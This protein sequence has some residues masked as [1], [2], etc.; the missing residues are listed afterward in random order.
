MHA[1]RSEA[2]GHGE[3]RRRACCVRCALRVDRSASSVSLRPP[4]LPPPFEVPEVPH[5]TKMHPRHAAS[6]GPAPHSPAPRPS[7][8]PHPDS[9]PARPRPAHLPRLQCERRRGGPNTQQ[10][11]QQQAPGA[12]H[13]EFDA[14]PWRPPCPP[15]RHP[16]CCARGGRT[17]PGCNAKEAGWCGRRA[18]SS[19]ASSLVALP[20]VGRT[21]LSS[22]PA[23]QPM[24]GSC[25]PLEGRPGVL[26]GAWKEISRESWWRLC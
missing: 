8:A 7:A 1:W 13:P 11:D 20:Y 25:Q 26:V 10:L 9:A 21:P 18:P 23:C 4:C 6:G 17:S 24:N 15:P 22:P 5:P 16:S 2:R 19:S 12:A 14:P 3:G